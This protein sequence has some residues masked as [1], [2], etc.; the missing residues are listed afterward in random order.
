MKKSASLSI[1]VPCHNEEEV[2]NSTYTTLSS[3]AKNWQQKGS[4]T[5][6]ELIFTNN[7][8]TD[9]TLSV[10]LD[11]QKND[12]NVVI[13]DLRKDF[14][15]QGSITAGLFHAN[16][17]MIV[18]IDADLQDDPKVIEQMI[19]KY[20][21]G[22]EMVLGVRET[23]QAD[24]F[25]KR[26]TA[27]SFYKL[28]NRL[29]IKTVYNHADFRLLS[30]KAVEAL[31]QF[32]ERVR[33]LRGLIF[34]IEG[35]YTTVKYARTKRQKGKSKFSPRKLFSFALDG[36]TSFS[37]VPIRII[38]FLGFVMFFISMIGFAFVI[39]GKFIKQVD[40][41]GWAFL[42][43]IIFFFGGLQSLFLGIIGEYIA[44]I[45]LESKQRPLYIVRDVY[46]NEN[47]NHDN[48]ENSIDS[49]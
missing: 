31:K 22:Y 29:G 7:G 17:D 32:P 26:I 34:Q 45:F 24:T 18:S 20:Y 14:G 35:K 21:D 19:E 39:Y 42:S 8:S 2:L 12:T 10:M 47:K 28:I 25:L 16:H 38:S 27:Q 11:I 3:L 6:Y 33:F 15:F 44:K 41:P 13:V 9:N 49:F 5:K 23:R 48:K 37:T 46:G 40:V 30:K 36:I 43:V 4:I 1:V